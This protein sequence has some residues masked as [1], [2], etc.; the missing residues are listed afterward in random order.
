MSLER[1]LRKKER[2]KSGGLASCSEAK[3]KGRTWNQEPVFAE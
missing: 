1:K 2:R 3:T